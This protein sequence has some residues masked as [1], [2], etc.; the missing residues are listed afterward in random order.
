MKK[1]ITSH[2]GRNC[3][4]RFLAKYWIE[5]NIIIIEVGMNLDH[6]F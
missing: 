1:S 4:V 2:V 5:C 6:F 3:S